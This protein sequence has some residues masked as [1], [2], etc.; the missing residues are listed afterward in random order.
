MR[1]PQGLLF[2]WL[3]KTSS[4]SLS[5]YERCSSS[6]I[7][8]VASP[9]STPTAPHFFLSWG[10]PGLDTVLQM[11]YYEATV[12]RNNHLPQPSDHSSLDAT[13]DTVGFLGCSIHCWLTFSFS[14]TMTPISFSVGLHSMS[15]S[16][17][18]YTSLRLPWFKC[19]TLRLVLLNLFRSTWLF[20]SPEL[21]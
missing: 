14:S 5:S 7:I 9:G 16:R 4:L 17:G 21:F 1:S 3:N 19:N 2:S 20:Y 10:A 15:S 11:G 13:Q 6:L 12:Q 8:L 18:L